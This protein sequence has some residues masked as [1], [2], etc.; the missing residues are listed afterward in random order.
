MMEVKQEKVQVVIPQKPKSQYKILLCTQILGHVQETAALMEWAQRNGTLQNKW[1]IALP[2]TKRTEITKDA[3][4]KKNIPIDDVTCSWSYSGGK[5]FRTGLEY[6]EDFSKQDSFST[7]SGFMAAN[8]RLCIEVAKGKYAVVATNF[9]GEAQLM[10]AINSNI[11]VSGISHTFLSGGL[12]KRINQHHDL[13]RLTF[14]LQRVQNSLDLVPKRIIAL[15]GDVNFIDYY[16]KICREKVHVLDTLIYRSFDFDTNIP[17]KL[18]NSAQVIQVP[19]IS[20]DTTI[21]KKKAREKIGKVISEEIKPTDKIIILAGESDD[22]SFRRRA[23][24]VIEFA[25]KR[26]DVHIIMP[27]ELMDQRISGLDIPTNAHAIGFRQDWFDIMAGGDITLIRGSWGEI[28]DL[29]VSHAI[30]IIT[31][32]STVPMNCDLDTT[33]FLTQVSEERACNISL[34]IKALQLRGIKS[35]MINKLIVDFNNPLDKHTLKEAI[36]YALQLDVGNELHS[37]ISSI[38]RGNT[39][40]VG[41]LHE[42]LLDQKRP[43]SASELTK[44]Q[45]SIWGPNRG[46][47]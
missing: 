14:M 22:G 46:T 16:W 9:H 8:A 3:L 40:W 33:Q 28:R 30:P 18:D 39:E 29:V 36:E 37:A 7:V 23:Q 26:H 19:F 38:P 41:V 11:L 13:P 34:F 42:Q 6:R 31:S 4:R 24:A 47:T 5:D 27:L 20:P 17:L 32:P 44:I 10:K 1:K 43:F 12:K 25:R 45:N 35:E 15:G 2:A 21:S